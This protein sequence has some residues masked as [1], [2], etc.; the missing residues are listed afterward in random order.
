MSSTSSL[1]TALLSLDQAVQLLEAA[2][3]R[4]SSR[5]DMTKSAEAELALMRMDRTRLA[6]DLD[7]AVA[8]GNALD[9]ARSDVAARLD[10][11]IATI[12]DTLGNQSTRKS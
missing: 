5:D 1:E 11:A 9:S 2:S 12:R 6:E 3:A 10:R 7:R 4:R 8:R